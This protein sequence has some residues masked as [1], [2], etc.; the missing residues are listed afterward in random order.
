M[1]QSNNKRTKKTAKKEALKTRRT[2]VS[3]E[4]VFRYAHPFYDEKEFKGETII[5][6]IKGKLQ[7]FQQTKGN[8]VMLLQEIIGSTAVN[9]INAHGSAT[10]HLLGDSGNEQSETPAKV[11][12]AMK[13]DFDFKK[14]ATSPALLLHLG[15]VNYYNNSPLGYHGQFYEA[16]KYYPAKIIAIPGNHDG[17]LLKWDGSSTKQTKPLEGFM[18]NFCQDK[19]GI[20]PDAGSIYRQM[21]N[22]PGVYWMLDSPFVDVIGLY[23][24]CAENP[25]FIAAS[26]IGTFQKKWLLERLKEVKAKRTSGIK[27]ALAILTHHPPLSHSGHSGSKEMLQDI[28]ACCNEVGLMYDVFIS[29]H[30]HNYQRFT[31]MVTVD[32]KKKKIP[33][34]VA[35]TGGRGITNVTDADGSKTSD[36]TYDKSLKGYGYIKAIFSATKIELNFLQ[37][38]AEGTKTLFDKVEVK[39]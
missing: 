18:R 25:G 4:K 23:S 14:P 21:H 37:V 39:L 36:Y 15:D 9:E 31:R 26:E 38:T 8:G 16:Y 11:A 17:E 6:H 24:N 19:A 1:K 10:F 22:Q 34:L 3:Q 2:S 5:D 29:G 32:N 35:G 30:A 28:D 27:K 33:F 20:P 7:P 12:D 13:A